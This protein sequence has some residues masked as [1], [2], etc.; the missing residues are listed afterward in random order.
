[1]VKAL[2]WRPRGPRF[3]SHYSNRYFFHLGVY[4]ALPKKVS[5]CGL[6]VFLPDDVYAASFG[7]DVKPLVPGYCPVTSLATPLVVGF[8]QTV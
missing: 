1:V 3:Q 8:C 7:R 2:D 4:S 6:K 5:R